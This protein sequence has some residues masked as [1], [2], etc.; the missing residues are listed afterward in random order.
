MADAADLAQVQE[1]GLLAEALAS[2]KAQPDRGP[3]YIDSVAC[4]RECE[5]AI[6]AARL[7]ALPGV[8]LCITCAEEEDLRRR[9]DRA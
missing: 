1:A 8:G 5:E 6:P 9:F 3:V 2:A 4:C 7:I